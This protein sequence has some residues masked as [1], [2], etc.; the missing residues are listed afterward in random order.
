MAVE[1]NSKKSKYRQAGERRGMR[2]QPRD[3][4]MLWGIYNSDGVLARRHL[5][6]MFWQNASLRAMLRRLS[7]LVE[8][9]YLARPSRCQWKT[10]PIPEAIYWL[11]YRGAIWIAE[12]MGL[13]I[14]PPKNSGENQ[15]RKLQR[16]LREQGAPWMREPRWGKIHHDLTVVDFRLSLERSVGELPNISI[17]QWVRESEFRSNMDT[18]E[19]RIKDKDGK[20]VR[21][22]RGVCPDFF[23]VISDEGRKKSGKTHR[24]PIL[25]E[26]DMGTHPVSSRFKRQKAAPYAAYIKSP[27]YKERFGFETGVWLMVTTGRRRLRNLIKQTEGTVGPDSAY[28]FFTLFSELGGNILT[29]PIWHQAGRDEPGPLFKF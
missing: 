21:A 18:I 27:A 1:T 7:L 15:M 5:K 28:F 20:V 8:H 17:E 3:G 6:R 11:D 25:L 23:F 22:K 2:F 9:D 10:K 29:A 24:L 16:T 4:E 13:E 19:F 26:I 12:Q 14:E